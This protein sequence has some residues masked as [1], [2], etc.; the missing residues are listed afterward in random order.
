[1]LHAHACIPTLP[2]G[3]TFQ[4]EN[5]AAHGLI[6]SYLSADRAIANTTSE[7]GTRSICSP[8]TLLINTVYRQE[9]ALPPAG[10]SPTQ[11]PLP[12]LHY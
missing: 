6:P 11:Q 3:L 9:E 8:V 5:K 10:Y 7:L 4:E 1:M 2:L 12:V